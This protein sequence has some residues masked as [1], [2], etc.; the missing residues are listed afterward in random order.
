MEKRLCIALQSPWAKHRIMDHHGICGKFARIPMDVIM[1]FQK[2]RRMMKSAHLCHPERSEG[3]IALGSG[4]LRCAQGDRGV[5]HTDAWI[6]VFVCIIWSLRIIQANPLLQF[7]CNAVGVALPG[8]DILDQLL[9]LILG[10][11]AS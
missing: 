2:I 4:M 3:S 10:H 7:S 6:N 9:P 1:Q 8:S 5:T 11:F